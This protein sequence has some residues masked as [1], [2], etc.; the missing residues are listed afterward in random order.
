MP[1][2]NRLR[3]ALPLLRPAGPSAAARADAT[4]N[5]HGPPGT[6]AV[7]AAARPSRRSARTVEEAAA[8]SSAA[9]A[10]T[11]EPAPVPGPATLLLLGARL[12]GAAAA[13]RRR[14]TRRTN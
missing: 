14:P 4:A 6:S 3:A 2:V 7:N 13:G 1:R 11:F 8:A 9:A 5:A 12:A 10:Y